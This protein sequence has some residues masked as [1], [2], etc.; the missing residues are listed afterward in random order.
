VTAAEDDRDAAVHLEVR[1]GW[2]RACEAWDDAAHHDAL[3][4]LVAQHNCFAWAAARYRERAGDAVADRQLER[5]RKAATAAM[6]ATATVRAQREPTPYRSS[7]AVLVVLLILVV[8]G[9][10]YLKTVRPEQPAVAPP[11]APTPARH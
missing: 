4:G 7:I 5:L 11:P 10:V 2:Q 8:L 9:V 3:L 1:A 6:F